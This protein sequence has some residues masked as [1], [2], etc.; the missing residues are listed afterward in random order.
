MSNQINSDQ[1][2]H[3]L[4]LKLPITEPATTKPKLEKKEKTES[5]MKRYNLVI[6]EILFNEVQELATQEHTTVVDLLRRFIKLGL[7]AARPNV[8]LIMRE[9]GKEREVLLLT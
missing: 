1:N 3:Q 2:K 5:G 6:P 7:I 4:D 9:E 8:V